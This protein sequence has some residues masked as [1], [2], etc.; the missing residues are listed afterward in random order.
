MRW[1]ILVGTWHYEHT[2]AGSDVT[3]QRFF[4]LFFAVKYTARSNNRHHGFDANIVKAV[5]FP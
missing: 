3:L 1:E 4:S 5:F 2:K